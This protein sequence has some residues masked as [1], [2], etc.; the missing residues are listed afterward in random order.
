[1]PTSAHERPHG[2]TSDTPAA[3]KLMGR[4]EDKTVLITGGANGQGAQ[5]A[6]MWVAG[7]GRVLI[8]DV[9]D[10]AG[11][12]LAQELGERARFVHLDVSQE[13]DWSAAMQC[14]QS[15]NGLHGLVNNAAIYQPQDLDDTSLASFERHVRVNQVGCFLGMQYAA[16]LMRLGGG[17]SIVNISSTAG[18]RGSPG[19]FAYC[20]TKWAMRGMTKSAALHLATDGIRVNSVHPGPIDTEMI[21]FRSE[22]AMRQR[23]AKVPLQR[24]GTADEVAAMVVFLL[25]DDS[26]YMTG[27]EISVDGGVSL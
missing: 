23:I 25:S 13:S 16:R 22:E 5:E 8:G 3:R 21:R 15:D 4:Y 9:D 10:T 27:A 20:A 6:R 19:S 24:L 2:K 14:A 12:A 7:G 18:L 11:T 26:A 17:G 1:M